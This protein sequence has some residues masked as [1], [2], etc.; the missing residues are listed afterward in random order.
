MNI[1]F[2]RNAKIVVALFLGN[3]LLLLNGCRKS[4]HDFEGSG[5]SHEVHWR[6]SF[7]DSCRDVTTDRNDNLIAECKDERGRWHK[8]F[9]SERS[10]SSHR[11]DNQ[12]GHLVCSNSSGG[13]GGSGG[14]HHEQWNGSFKGSCQDIKVDGSGNLNASC[15]NKSGRRERA[16]LS[17]RDC[18][19]HQAGNN[20]GKLVCEN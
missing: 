5:G 16:F 15:K 2:S 20:N 3:C 17:S 11:A 8:R 12:N 10:C 18:R 1:S 14:S 4:S 9:L 7:N 6:G 19:S 13:F